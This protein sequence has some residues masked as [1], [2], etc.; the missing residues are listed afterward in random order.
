MVVLLWDGEVIMT[1]RVW[2][3]LGVHLLSRRLETAGVS[4]KCI[5][6]GV[7]RVLHI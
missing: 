3:L 7:V 1:R 4:C 2:R 5:E 6:G